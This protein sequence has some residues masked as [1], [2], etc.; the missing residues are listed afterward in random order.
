MA[1]KLEHL[2]VRRKGDKVY[3]YFRRRG[4]PKPVR[5]RGLYG[6]QEFLTAYYALLHAAEKHTSTI[7]AS[8][9][10]A[11]T[12]SATIAAL[13]PSI[14]FTEGQHGPR[15]A[16]S[17]QTDRNLLESF[18]REYGD[19]SI[20]TMQTKHVA[21][22]LAKIAG[23]AAKRNKLRVMRLL[24]DF[25]V[26]QG[27]RKDNP[28]R[29]IKLGKARATNGFHS[30]IEDEL[31]QYETRHPIGSMARLAFALLLY[32]AQRRQDI[33]HLGPRNLQ[34]GRMVFTQSKT[35]ADMDIPVAPPLAKI[36]AETP[37][38]GLRTFL[39]TSFGK[40]FSDNGFGN[41]FRDRCNEANLL[42]CTAHG[43]RKAFMRRM[44]EAGCSEDYIAAISGHTEMR[45]IRVYV[46]AARRARM[47]DDAMEITLARFPEFAAA[48]DAS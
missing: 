38:V 10:A 24:L 8:R 44:A 2:D 23:P 13:Y 29:A 43:M 1:K 36:I 22:I 3:F 4:M 26:E 12:V 15:K 48:G 34:N 9:A 14:R 27:M 30:W 45:E 37:M 16:I 39:V 35:G 20:V 31:R 32:T 18:R 47:A 25:A 41:W 17:L 28:A 5:I 46:R 11:G 6:S 7:G 19:Q 33:I 40:G 42:H 21:D